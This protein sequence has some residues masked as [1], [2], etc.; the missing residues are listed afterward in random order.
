VA[1]DPFQRI[2]AVHWGGFA[3]LEITYTGSF[4]FE[5]S[6]DVTQTDKS[7]SVGDVIAKAG[8]NDAPLILVR[9]NEP[10]PIGSEPGG[11]AIKDLFG[12]AVLVVHPP[13]TVE[14]VVLPEDQIVIAQANYDAAVAGFNAAQLRE[15]N[16]VLPLQAAALTAFLALHPEAAVFRGVTDLRGWFSD[17]P[18]GWLDRS[19]T[20]FPPPYI[21]LDGAKPVG[22]HEIFTFPGY[23]TFGSIQGVMLGEN[24]PPFSTAQAFGRY[25]TYE[26]RNRD[27]FIIN[28]GKLGAQV[29]DIAMQSL[30][31]QP[32]ELV[33]LSGGGIY[34]AAAKRQVIT[35]AENPTRTVKLVSGSGK[36]VGA[37][38]AR[39]DRGGFVV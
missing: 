2:I 3:L 32:I 8:I 7:Y 38:I 17:P 10:N 12:E 27:T 15:Y 39:F 16:R 22:P 5:F 25:P 24:L 36:V 33:Y 37:V 29:V 4:P 28:T 26:N 11:Y 23:E 6:V 19:I 18:G 20:F 13:I 1:L 14:R 30:N 34:S 21:S 9:C 35:N 31:D